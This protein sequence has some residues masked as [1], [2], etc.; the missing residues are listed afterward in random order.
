M[1]NRVLRAATAAAFVFVLGAIPAM[2]Q[3]PSTTQTPARETDANGRPL[4]GDGGGRL[5][6]SDRS[7]GARAPRA[8]SPEEVK[9]AVQGLL[10][11][12]STTCQPTETVLRGQGGEG[13]TIYETAC[14]TGPGYI[15]IS[16]T[17][18]QAV[19]CVILFGQADI[20]RAKDPA[21]DVGLQCQIPANNNVLAVISAYAKEAGVSCAVD[22]AGTVG[23]SAEGNIV[24]EVGCPGT[25]GYRLEKAAAGW[26]TT[27]CM[28]LASMNSA[29][30]FTTEAESAAT[31][32]GWLTGSAA[33]AC[34]VTQARYMG[35]NANG[36]FYEA[37]C[38]AGDGY[39]AR[40]DAQMAVQQ[41]YPCTEAQRI[42][43]G[44][45]LTV[46][47]DAPAPA[48]APVTQQ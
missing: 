10:T 37:K 32:K 2:A 4:T 15:L 9:T 31:L 34:D 36:A 13:Q 23:K 43:G 21:A 11:A 1:F 45:K 6:Q 17:P 27:E 8:P 48:A 24:Y 7:R 29:C 38:G 20:T 22:Q 46:V 5:R 41:V 16:A 26:T 19:D 30:K 18:P 40:L 44:C 28:K 3:T 35:A 14:A 39:V 33:A 12:T 42:G 25:D 47:P